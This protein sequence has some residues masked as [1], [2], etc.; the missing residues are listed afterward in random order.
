M[1]HN[2]IEMALSGND[3][4]GTNMSPDESAVL[5]MEAGDSV[6]PRVPFTDLVVPVCRE[7]LY[8]GIGDSG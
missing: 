5:Y 6:A 2:F 4:N 3:S 1:V 8:K 7:I